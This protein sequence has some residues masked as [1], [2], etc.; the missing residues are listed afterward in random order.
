MQCLLIADLMLPS[1]S[2][3]GQISFDVFPTGWD[4][5]YCLRHVEN[6]KNLPEGVDYTTIHF[7]GD[8]CFKGGNDY[9]IY[10]DPR[11]IGHSVKDPQDTMAE[12]KKLFDL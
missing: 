8:K 10:E 2:I 12:L 11:T 9:E 6:E 4:K 5:T 7:F 3:G 1:Y